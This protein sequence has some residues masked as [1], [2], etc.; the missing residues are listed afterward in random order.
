MRLISWNVQWGRSAHGD[1][2]LSRTIDEARRL[3]DFDVLCMQEITRGFSVL[4]GHPGDDQF[5]ELADLLPG[6]TVLGA[7]G[8]DLAPLKLDAP[9]APRRQ[10]GNALAT[11]LPVERVIRHSL[12]WPADP[13]SPS[14]QRVALEAVLRAPGG[15]VRVIVTHLEFYSLKQ[16][17][18]QVERLRE[19]QQEAAAH[20]ANPAPAENAIGPFADT[21]RPVSAI[22]CGDFNSAYGSEAYRRM[23][24]PLAGSPSFVDAWTALHPG[25]T[26]P[27]TA[28]VYD[29]AQWVDGPLACDFVF[30]TDD[31]LPRLVS[32]EVDGTTRCSDHQPFVVEIE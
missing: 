5:A 27:M 14:M 20:A 16:R 7:I 24:E 1:V 6:Y 12:P 11:R 26:P 3:A 28:G 8:A 32:C 22:V 25:Q 31:L 19:M 17:L 2:N 29:K 18:A 15:P 10:F 9:A 30:V 4:A 23:L 21:G 13:D